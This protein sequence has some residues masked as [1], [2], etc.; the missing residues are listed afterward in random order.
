METQLPVIQ[1]AIVLV[2]KLFELFPEFVSIICFARSMLKDNIIQR[3]NRINLEQFKDQWR[4]S[5]ATRR[6]KRIH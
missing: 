1:I 3:R 5:F 6:K 2:N 4:H